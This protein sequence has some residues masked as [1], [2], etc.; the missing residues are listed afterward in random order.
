MSHLY[1]LTSIQD[2]DKLASALISGLRPGFVMGLSGP[3]GVGKTTFVQALVRALG[4]KD[5]VKS[6]TFA[7]MRWY[8]V[9]HPEIRRVIHVDAYRLEKPEDVLALNLAEELS[10]G[11]SILVVEWPE[12]MESFFAQ[13][14]ET[15]KLLLECKQEGQ[16]RTVS[17]TGAGV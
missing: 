4:G 9:S 17:I 5:V 11:E 12:K 7:L 6:P 14:P 8:H 10:D 2:W 16:E 13:I 1:Q 3:L 15:Q